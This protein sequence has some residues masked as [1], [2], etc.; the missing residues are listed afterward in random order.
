[1]KPSSPH[2]LPDLHLVMIV[3]A[4]G[5]LLLCI[6]MY[7]FAPTTKAELFATTIATLCGFLFGKF[8]NGFKKTSSDQKEGSDD[9]SDPSV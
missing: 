7:Y 3:I 5:L 4:T 6:V 2:P 1:M 8:T 9:P